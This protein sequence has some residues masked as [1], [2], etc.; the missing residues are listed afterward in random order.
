MRVHRRASF[1]KKIHRQIRSLAQRLDHVILFVA[2]DRPSA[3]VLGTLNRL[4][5][6]LPA[7]VEPI[8][9]HAPQVLGETENWMG[10]LRNIWDAF[11][12]IAGEPDAGILWDD[13]MVFARKA[14]RALR[15]HFRLLEYDRVEALS[16]FFWDSSAQYNREFPP[17]WS[18][19]LWRVYPGDQFPKHFE[20]HSPEAT[21]R[22][23][24]VMYLEYPILNYGYL[25]HE[26]RLLSWNACKTAGK[27]DGHT[28]TL[29]K[30]PDLVQ[31]QSDDLIPLEW[32]RLGPRQR[33]ELENK[34]RASRSASAPSTKKGGHGSQ[35][36]PA[37]SNSDLAHAVGGTFPG[38]TLPIS[39][40]Q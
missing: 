18:T 25:T 21:A 15:R 27:V 17:H 9:W 20:T 4:H 24:S 31:W 32:R 39:L 29:T 3:E 22:S 23:D 2:A 11:R 6:N 13:D 37:S 40:F 16:L 10:S 33:L 35:S 1:L 5:K 34:L 19:V 28:L 14:L 36:K 30:E 38:R 7:N 8:I 26:A 12:S